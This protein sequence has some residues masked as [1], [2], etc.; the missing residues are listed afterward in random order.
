M[1]GSATPWLA[2]MSA[3]GVAAPSGAG[4]STANGDYGEVRTVDELITPERD[5]ALRRAALRHAAGMLHVSLVEWDAGEY[6]PDE[7]EEDRVREEVERIA[8]ELRA[9]ALIGTRR[10]CSVCGFPYLVR[11]DG[12]VGRHAG[13]DEAGFSTGE[14]CAGV[15]RPPRSN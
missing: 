10:P 2:R 13:T 15:G 11:K 5:A 4:T 14:R 8:D 9:R 6:F 1:I 12:A 7:A 3:A